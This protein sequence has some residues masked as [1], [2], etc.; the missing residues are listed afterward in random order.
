MQIFLLCFGVHNLRSVL[1]Q[2]IPRRKHLRSSF[3]LE[4]PIDL[5][6]Q[7]NFRSDNV[8]LDVRTVTEATFRPVVASA[9]QAKSSCVLVV[10]D[11]TGL[12]LPG[13][14]APEGA[15]LGP[16]ERH[17]LRQFRQRIR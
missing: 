1:F 7:R 2:L 12:T 6:A 14:C 11:T 5:V 13:P 10:A 3:P 9:Y 4:L 16:R 17:G 8:V 15:F